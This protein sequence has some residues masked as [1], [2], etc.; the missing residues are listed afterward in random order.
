M[1]HCIDISVQDTICICDRT[2]H[3]K[4][5]ISSKITVTPSHSRSCSS[6]PAQQPHCSRGR[7]TRGMLH[8][9]H[10][11]PKNMPMDCN[12]TMLIHNPHRAKNQG[13]GRSRGRGRA[14]RGRGVGRGRRRGRG[15][16]SSRSTRGDETSEKL[17]KLIDNN[18]KHLQTIVNSTN[19]S[20]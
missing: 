10:E 16:N 1:Y 7:R 15:R 9:V 17:Q 4:A 2:Y 11:T 19:A 14:R 6:S 20:K 5:I 13:R 3:V 18:Q 12:L 8:L